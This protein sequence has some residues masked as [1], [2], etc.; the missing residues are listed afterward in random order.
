MSGIFYYGTGM[1]LLGFGDG[2]RCVGGTV[3]RLPLQSAD[4][5]GFM[6]RSVFG[7]PMPNVPISPTTLFFQAWFRDP[8]A[9]MTGFN[10]SDGVMVTFTP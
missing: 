6:S 8:P 9:M 10:L 2:F 4:A 5:S 7:N 3:Q 1:N